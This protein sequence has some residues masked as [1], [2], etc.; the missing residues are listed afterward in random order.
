MRGTASRYYPNTEPYIL[1]TASLEENGGVIA[2]LVPSIQR[3]AA[4]EKK[5]DILIRTPL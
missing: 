2:V 1:R 3:F 4:P 5:Q